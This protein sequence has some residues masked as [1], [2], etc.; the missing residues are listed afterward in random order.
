MRM[1]WLMPV[2]MLSFP[3]LEVMRLELAYWSFSAAE[4]YSSRRRWEGRCLRAKQIY[5]AIAVP[6][7]PVQIES[8]VGLWVVIRQASHG[9]C[10]TVAGVSPG[11]LCDGSP[12]R[13]E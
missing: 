1:V 9:L 11:I 6:A 3:A 8:L 10:P 7:H 5:A 13:N 2:D 12:A 4:S